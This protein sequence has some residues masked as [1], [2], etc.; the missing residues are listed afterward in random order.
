MIIIVKSSSNHH[1]SIAS[2]WRS[3]HNPLMIRTLMITFSQIIVKMIIKEL[4]SKAIPNSSVILIIKI[5][6]SKQKRKGSNTKKLPWCLT[7]VIWSKCIGIEQSRPEKRLSSKLKNCR[8]TN[9]LHSCFNKKNLQTPMTWIHQQKKNTQ[10][11]LLPL[12]WESS[13]A[14][15]NS[16]RNLIMIFK[17]TQIFN[18]CLYNNNKILKSNDLRAKKPW[19]L[20][21]HSKA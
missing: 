1:R 14:N 19:S 9:C 5:R 20:R 21:I 2:L 17:L 12:M 10:L 6:K 18:G 3:K 4:K 16:N 13:K 15:T 11:Q 7:Q 8:S